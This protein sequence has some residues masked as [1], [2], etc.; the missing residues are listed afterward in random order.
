MEADSVRLGRRVKGTITSVA[1]INTGAR[2]LC[3][4]NPHR[5]S[6]II[7]CPTAARITIGDH[8]NVTDTNGLVLFASGAPLLLEI[9]RHGTLVT[10]GLFA[11][12]QTGAAT[13]GVAECTLLPD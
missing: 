13:V 6:L 5:V 11:I 2:E 1:L 4:P 9:D 10:N 8:S 12:H 3:G 7:T